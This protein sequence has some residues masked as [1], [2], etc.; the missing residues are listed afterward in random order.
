MRVVPRAGLTK[1]LISPEEYLRRER[2]AS[3]RS[4]YLD[5][6]VHAMAGQNIAPG[7]GSVNLVVHFG[8]QRKGSACRAF[9]KDTKVRSGPPQPRG[10]RLTGGM[11]SYPDVLVVCE[12]IEPFDD[13][14]EV[15][16]NPTTIFEVLSE[17]TE[18]FDR[19]ER[20]AW[21]GD[22]NSPLR[23]DLLVAQDEP[24]IDHFTRQADGS[25]LM[26]SH[27][28]LDADVRIDSIGCSRKLANVYDSV[29]FPKPKEAPIIET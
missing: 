15:I 19:G 25:W 5:G 13:H 11:F 21:L 3:E 7:T 23:D 9:T 1:T 17:S 22:W 26:R 14:R 29:E 6:Q 4:C 12:P 18:A 24:R 10:E 2:L 16:L 27:V 28:G 8:L 20:F